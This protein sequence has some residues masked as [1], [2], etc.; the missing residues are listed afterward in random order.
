MSTTSTGACPPTSP[1]SPTIE[2]ARPIPLPPR[3][4]VQAGRFYSNDRTLEDWDGEFGSLTSRDSPEC[5]PHTTGRK[6]E[7][8]ASI[9]GDISRDPLLSADGFGTTWPQYPG[10]EPGRIARGVPSIRHLS[11]LCTDPHALGNVPG[12]QGHAV[13]IHPGAGHDIDERF[14]RQPRRQALVPGAR[15]RDWVAR[16]CHRDVKGNRV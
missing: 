8:C 2:G 11:R 6:S 10:A 7:V 4:R 14:S 9:W 12:P 1:T 13:G 15:P 5:R 16:R 3:S